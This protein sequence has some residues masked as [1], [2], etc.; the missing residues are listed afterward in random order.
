MRAGVRR[1]RAIVLLG[2][3]IVLLGFTAIVTV[4]AAQATQPRT[5]AGSG[6]Q[7]EPT[8]NQ[9]RTSAGINELSAVSCTSGRACTAVGE[10]DASLSSPSFTLA[11]RWNGVS[12]QIQPTVLPKGA[13][14]SLSAACPARQR[15]PAPP[16]ATL[17]SRQHAGV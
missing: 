8:P 17:S 1:A 16:W 14:G 15:P 12:W 4:G 9:N 3:V 7:V 2:A 11:E 6:W 13:E 10:H 5:D